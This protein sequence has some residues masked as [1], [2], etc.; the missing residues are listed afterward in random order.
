LEPGELVIDGLLIEGKL[1]VPAGSIRLHI[2]HSTLVPSSGGIKIE[3]DSSV[4]LT[5]D[6]SICGRIEVAGKSS[7]L[8][9]NES[10]IDADGAEKYPAIDAEEIAAR[11]DRCTILGRSKLRRLEASNSIFTDEVT[12]RLRQEGCVRFSYITH[13]SHSPRRFHCQPDM[14]LAAAKEDYGEA[15]NEEEIMA[16][17]NRLD[18]A[19]ISVHYGDPG[20]VQLSRSSAQEI[21]KGAEDGSEMGIYGILQQPQREANLRMALEEYLRFGLEAGI[22]FV[23]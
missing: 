14:A 16:V 11:M 1:S 6:R 8:I 2:A 17:K 13:D 19:F 10:I 3:G 7:S 4:E 9:V 18:P 22:F 12:A 15:L 23:T 5:I 20:Y 21:L